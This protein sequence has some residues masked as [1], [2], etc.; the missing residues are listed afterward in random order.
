VWGETSTEGSNPSLSASFVPLNIAHHNSF[1]I[2]ATC[3]GI[4]KVTVKKAFREV[5]LC[6]MKI[7]MN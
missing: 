5:T 6:Q 2:L 4:E 3:P 7:K 1:F